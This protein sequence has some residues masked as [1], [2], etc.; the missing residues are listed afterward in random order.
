MSACYTERNGR[1]KPKKPYQKRRMAERAMS[2]MVA[3]RGK[4]PADFKVYRCPVCRYFHFGHRM[5]SQR[6]GRVAA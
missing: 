2:R 4:N 1:R 5:Q 6:Q 3:S